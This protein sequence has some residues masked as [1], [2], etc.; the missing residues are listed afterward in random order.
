MEWSDFWDHH[1]FR[2]SNRSEKRQ[3]AHLFHPLYR[4]GESEHSCSC[5]ALVRLDLWQT[6]TYV[7]LL[8]LLLD[9]KS[10][11]ASPQILMR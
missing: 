5:F 11:C 6:A 3:Y 10:S 9:F 1:S 8:L 2:S 4:A 7:L